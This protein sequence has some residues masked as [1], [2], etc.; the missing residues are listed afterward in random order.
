MNFTFR[1]VHMNKDLLRKKK[2]QN[3]I[4]IIIPQQRRDASYIIAKYYR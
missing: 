4:L 1:V 3:L 2:I